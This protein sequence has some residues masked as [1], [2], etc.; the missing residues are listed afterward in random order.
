M[1]ILKKRHP[2]L[3][4]VLTGAGTE[5]INGISDKYGVQLSSD[6]NRDIYGLGYIDND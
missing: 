3:K 2:N 4:L 5:I 1:S 6:M